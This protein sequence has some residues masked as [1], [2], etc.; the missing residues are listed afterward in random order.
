MV[1]DLTMSQSAIKDVE[2]GGSCKFFPNK[3]DLQKHGHS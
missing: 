2:K 3:I 1:E